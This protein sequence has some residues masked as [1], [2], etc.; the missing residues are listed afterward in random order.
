M[1]HFGEHFLHKTDTF[2]LSQTLADS[3]NETVGGR[4]KEA[5]CI[6]WEESDFLEGELAARKECMLKARLAGWVGD[7]YVS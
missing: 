4:G 1:K 5:F 6:L 3:N 2:L 7:V